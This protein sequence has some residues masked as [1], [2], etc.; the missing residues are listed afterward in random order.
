[1]QL[2][3]IE[4]RC[5]PV[6]VPIIYCTCMQCTRR[7]RRAP[8]PIIVILRRPQN[9]LA[10]CP[11]LLTASRHS[12]GGRALFRSTSRIQSPSSQG[13]SDRG[14]FSRPIVHLDT[15]KC[16]FV[17]SPRVLSVCTR[18]A[19][20]R[21]PRKHASTPTRYCPSMFLPVGLVGWCDRWMMRR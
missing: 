11:P 21:R 5:Y 12:I 4:G 14:R 1:M 9:L 6:I 19:G 3:L 18:R 17:R 16:P 2:R 8:L 15:I 10:R 7:H 13:E 20:R